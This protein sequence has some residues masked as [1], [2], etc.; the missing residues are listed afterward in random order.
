MLTHDS[1]S[2]FY[3]RKMRARRFQALQFMLFVLVLWSFLCSADVNV[4]NLCVVRPLFYRI[5]AYDIAA[6][7]DLQYNVLNGRLAYCDK[8]NSTLVW[9]FIS[10]NAFPMW[11]ASEFDR[12]FAWNK[13]QIR[14]LI[15]TNKIQTNDMHLFLR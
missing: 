15:G 12:L 7:V 11:N 13:S 3:E 4:Y 2:V 6:H 9:A 1:L 5:I 8:R 14:H 10:Y